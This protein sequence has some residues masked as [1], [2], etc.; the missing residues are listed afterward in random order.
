MTVDS[1]DEDGH[2][3]LA[4]PSLS[5]AQQAADAL[6]ELDAGFVLLYGSVASKKA[7]T[8]SDIDL[9]VVFDD[10]GDYSGR[11]IVQRHAEDVVRA[12]TGFSANVHVTD[13]PEWAARLSCVSTFERHIAGYG[14]VLRERPARQVRWD[15]QTKLPSSDQQCAEQ[16]LRRLRL[17]LVRLTADENLA[18]VRAHDHTAEILPAPLREPGQENF[19]RVCVTAQLAMEAALRAVNH[20]LPSSYLVKPTLDT[21]AAVDAM[22]LRFDERRLLVEALETVTSAD[23]AVWRRVWKSEVSDQPRDQQGL[24][25]DDWLNTRQTPSHARDMA[26]AARCVSAAATQIARSRLQETAP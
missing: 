7:Q 26:A 24:P 23:V 9:C 13:R 14:V 3:L 11:E 16:M 6:E 1:R 12:A 22:P 4:A 15:K 8:G 5:D 20:S 18:G 17:V 25:E 2:G 19:G 21:T 10:L